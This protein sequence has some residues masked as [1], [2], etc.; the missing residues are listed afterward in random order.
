MERIQRQCT[1]GYRLPPGSV[2]VGRPSP[3]GNPFPVDGDRAMWAAVALGYNARR[4]GQRACAVMLYRAWMTGTQLTFGPRRSTG[5]DIEYTSGLIMPVAPAVSGLGWSMLALT[6]GL[7]W[8]GDP[9]D[10][11]PLRGASALACWCPLEEP[12]HADVIIDLLV[13]RT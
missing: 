13:E 11:A 10:L 5:G 2:Y 4:E 9:P 8:A 1:K 12:C 3:W 7:M 6:G